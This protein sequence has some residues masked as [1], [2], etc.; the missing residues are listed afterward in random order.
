MRNKD[1]WAGRK[2]AQIGVGILKSKF[3]K[4]HTVNIGFN[5]KSG[6][7]MWIKSHIL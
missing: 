5:S 7:T 4:Q 3:L 1:K 2:I 6:L